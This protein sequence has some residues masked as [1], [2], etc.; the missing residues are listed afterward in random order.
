MG[1]DARESVFGI[2]HKDQPAQLQRLA[3]KLKFGA[4]L[5]FVIGSQTLTKF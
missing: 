1:I 3:R 4:G 2:S 5:P